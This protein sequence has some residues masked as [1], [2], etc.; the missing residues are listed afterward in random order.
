MPAGFNV[1]G[2]Q[3]D[4]VIKVVGD[5]HVITV[6]GKQV[7]SFTDAT[8]KTGSAGLRSW[9]GGSSRQL[10]QRQ[11]ARQ[12][13]RQ[14]RLRRPEQ[15]RLRLRLRRPDPTYGLVGWLAGSSAFVIQPLR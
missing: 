11:G 2:A 8:Y 13:R 5:K 9:D 3:H 14:R 6:D 15:G 7:L 10:R 12:R 4:I 1:Y